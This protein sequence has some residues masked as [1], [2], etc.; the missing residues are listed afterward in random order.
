MVWGYL[1]SAGPVLTVSSGDTVTLHSFPAGG[2]ETLPDDL[3]LV[4]ADYLKALETLPPG[5]GPHFITGP[6]YVTGAQAG[7]TLQIE[8]LDVRARQDWGFASI[9]RAICTLPWGP[10]KKFS[11]NLGLPFW[12]E[13]LTPVPRS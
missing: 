8:I 7:D 3:S 13:P 11:L 6:V 2:K 1:D 5:P 10:E 4:L 9:A 12:Q